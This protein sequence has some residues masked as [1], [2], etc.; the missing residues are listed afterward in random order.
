MH[1]D[2]QVAIIT[3]GTR[4]IGFG[5]AT[6]LSRQGATVVLAARSAD[7][8]KQAL[9]DLGAGERAVFHHCDVR[10]QDQ[11]NAVVDRTIAE[12][13]R[14]D[15]LVNNAGGSDG[16]ALVHEL[17]DEAWQ[18]ALDWN[19]NGTFWA[20]RR[21]L[22]HM[23]AAGHG[24]IIN[25]TSVEGKQ[26]NKPAISHYV[27]NKHAINGFTKAVATEYGASGITCNAICPGAVE[28]D[29]MRENGP[30]VAAAEG[31]S[32]EQFLDGYRAQAKTKQ[33]NTVEQIGAVAVLLAG[34]HGGGLTGGLINVDGGTSEW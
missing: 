27:A 4:G 21:A 26:G 29:I 19:L 25:I 8:G 22:P 31:I 6:A 20:T 2:G 14:L 5:I 30:L 34:P 3:G 11:V 24:R 16:Y 17:T 1:L 7:K 12:F 18:N 28:T 9:A 15:I 32:Y 10:S 23:L 13:G 33:L